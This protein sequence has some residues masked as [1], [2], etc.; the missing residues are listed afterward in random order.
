MAVVLGVVF[1]QPQTSDVLNS[2][3]S[4]DT[5]PHENT[6]SHSFESELADSKDT[7]SSTENDITS[8]PPEEPTIDYLQEGGKLEL[9]VIGA[10][11]YAAVALYLYEAPDSNSNALL[12]LEAGQGFTIV[13]ETDQWWN[14][15]I[16]DVTGWVAHHLCLINLPDVI[17]SIIY[18]HTNS[19]ASIMHSSGID[20]PNITNQALYQTQ[21]YNNR[22][23]QDEFIV[24]ILYA[25]SKKICKA[26]QAALADGN[27]LIIYEAFRPYE[28]QQIIVKNLSDLIDTNPIVKAGVTTSPWSINW[29]VATSLSNHQ[30]GV[31]IDVSLGQINEQKTK[32]TGGYVY[33]QIISYTEYEMQTAMH[34]LSATSAIFKKPVSSISDTEW[35]DVELAATVTEASVL[36]Q[37][38][39]SNAGLTPLASEWWHFNDLENADIAKEIGNTGQY[40]IHQSFSTPPK[41]F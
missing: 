27:T 39:C 21:A 2:L 3:S 29:F 18:N 40:F 11:G 6:Q 38:Y 25:T 1:Y 8:S 35:R 30:R 26:Q 33:K 12:S 31:A 34:E 7:T 14:V 15:T 19:Y 17:P 9:P 13:S 5:S 32:I 36:L 10:S 28:I 22:F 24:P 16:G 37:T 41:D 20:I 23:N 4:S